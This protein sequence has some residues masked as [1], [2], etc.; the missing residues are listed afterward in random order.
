ME[1]LSTTFS[2]D[3]L[4]PVPLEYLSS[5]ELLADNIDFLTEATVHNKFEESSMICNGDI[6]RLAL[7]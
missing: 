7:S 2:A 5:V 6:M 1:P 3:D 4:E